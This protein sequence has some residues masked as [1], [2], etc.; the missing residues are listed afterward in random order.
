MKEIRRDSAVRDH[1]NAM[2][3]ILTATIAKPGS[4]FWGKIGWQPRWTDVTIEHKTSFENVLQDIARRNPMQQAQ[5]PEQRARFIYGGGASQFF[6][7]KLT[8][9]HIERNGKVALQDVIDG[10]ERPF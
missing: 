10:K 7:D 3:H 4:C 5:R 9:A 6:I 1:W 8:T 2:T